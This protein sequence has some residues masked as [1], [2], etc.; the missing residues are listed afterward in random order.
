[1]L[2]FPGRPRWHH[3]LAVKYFVTGGSGFVGGE[4]I[5]AL[6]AG[7]DEVAALARSDRAA[8]AV[9]AR[10]A[11]PVPGDLD[12]VDAMRAGMAGA[13]VVVHAAAMLAGGRAE[14]A[15]FRRIN[16]DGTRNLLAA[17]GDGGARV[18]IVSTEQVV[19]AGPLVDVD[20]TA[21][22]PAR[23]V[24][25]YAETKQRA[26]RAVLAAGGIAV[27]PRMVWGRGDTTLL[28]TVV[29]AARS[30]RLR[31]IGGGRQRSSTCHVRNVAAGIIAAARSGRPGEAY[32]LTDG[33]PVEFR[34]FWT[35][36]LATQ[37]VAAPT[38]TLPRPVAMA[39]AS[40][41]EAAWWALRR[42]GQPPLDR[43]T[44]A[45]L[46]DECTVRDAKARRELGYDPPVTIEAG[47][48]E[49]SG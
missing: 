28:P 8:D 29:D 34:D 4:L 9:R 27:R 37:G 41:A 43:M 12:D 39:A 25:L 40:L 13:D 30:G 11:T 19:M 45:L 7:G 42:P 17:A 24:G 16:V 38:G 35:R 46:S 47:L 44:V 20:E 2:P 15:A 49:M 33:E 18:V 10:G 3:D 32:F 21:P 48:A 1:M 26:E 22:Y 31:W 6:V 5:A 14:R 36:M 23:T